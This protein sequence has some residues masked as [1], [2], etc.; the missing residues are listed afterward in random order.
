MEPEQVEE[1]SSGFFFWLY[2]SILLFYET[3]NGQVVDAKRLHK[4]LATH[5]LCIKN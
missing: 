2:Y 4:K 5:I 3:D 1:A